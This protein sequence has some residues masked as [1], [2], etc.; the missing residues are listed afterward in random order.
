MSYNENDD[1]DRAYDTYVEDCLAANLDWRD[2]PN[3]YWKLKYGDYYDRKIDKTV[4]KN[5]KEGDAK[6]S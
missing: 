2:Y 4:Q 3:S 6:Q 1:N 5:K